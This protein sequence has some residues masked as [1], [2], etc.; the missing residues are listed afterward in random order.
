MTAFRRSSAED[1]KTDT[2]NVYYEAI[3]FYSVTEVNSPYA[4]SGHA[5]ALKDVIN[6]DI[7]LDTKRHFIA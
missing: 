6:L 4:A 2:L 5:P 1:R 7:A 3:A